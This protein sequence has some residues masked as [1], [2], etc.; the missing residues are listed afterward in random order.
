VNRRGFMGS[1]LAVGMAPAVVRASSLMPWR[2]WEPTAFRYGSYQ[3]TGLTRYPTLGQ[4]LTDLCG[5]PEYCDAESM[6][7]LDTAVAGYVIPDLVP[8]HSEIIRLQ[9]VYKFDL[10]AGE[11]GWSV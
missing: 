3:I 4:I 9:S 8:I 10:V 6:R 5:G 2:V 7:R 1:I 11:N